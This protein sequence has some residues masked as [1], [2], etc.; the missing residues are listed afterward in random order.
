MRSSEKYGG[1]PVAEFFHWLSG[2][3]GEDEYT[4][5][6]DGPGFFWLFRFQDGLDTETIDRYNDECAEDSRLNAE[7]ILML[8]AE[9]D[10]AILKE[11]SDGFVTVE[12][13]LHTEDL[14]R[15]WN[16]RV[17]ETSI[18]IC[19]ECGAEAEEYGPDAPIEHRVNCPEAEP[20][21]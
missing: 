4:G 15:D 7:E 1:Q 21:G 19:P 10:G 9:M 16:V 13:Y 18:I 6:S 3:N 5:D 2:Q 11:N 17:D 20:V 14:M 12:T 8:C